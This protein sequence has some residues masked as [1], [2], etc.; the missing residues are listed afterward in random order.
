M[1]RRPD[2]CATIRDLLL[3][4]A[5][6]VAFSGIWVTAPV[7][8][9]VGVAACGC[10][11]ARAEDYFDQALAVADRMQAPV[12]AERVALRSRALRLNQPVPN[13]SRFAITSFMIS[14][15]PPPIRCNRASRNARATGVSS[16]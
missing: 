15:V 3:P 9:G 4:F 14:S 5:D 16:R 11:D 8:Y 7:A 10:G 13:P 2:V 1:L 12:L 6:Q